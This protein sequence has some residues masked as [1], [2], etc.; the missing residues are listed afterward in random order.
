MM[1]CKLPSP[2]YVILS[3]ISTCEK[4]V[5]VPDVHLPQLVRNSVCAQLA[6]IA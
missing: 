5:P 1:L 3:D 6:I 4:V 2:V